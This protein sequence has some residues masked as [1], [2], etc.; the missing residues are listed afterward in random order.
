M[1]QFFAL[2]QP[3]RDR[4]FKQADPQG[5]LKTLAPLADDAHLLG[6]GEKT[7]LLELAALAHRA[8]NQYKEA[9]LLYDEIGDSYQAGYCELLRGNMQQV[10]LY[11]TRTLQ[12]RA[13]H[14]C[15]TLFGLATRQLSCFPTMFQIRNHMESDIANLIQANQG[16]L[17]NN[18]V[19]YVDVLTQ[20]NL[21]TPKFMGRAFL[22]AGFLEQAGP[23]LLKGQKAL[24]NDPEVYFHLGQYAVS[25]RNPEEARL[26]LN[27]CLLISPTYSPAKELMEKL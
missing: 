13:N 11:W 12:E 1:S 14:W 23:L 7:A 25:Q 5:A 18:V 20:V 22:H 19:S 27:Q 15:L 10:Q 17:L 2:L 21:E 8:L 6:S 9:V 4:L 26:M 24:P 16:Q 3:A